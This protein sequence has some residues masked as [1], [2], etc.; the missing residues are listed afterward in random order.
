[1]L[2]SFLSSIL[3]LINLFC[4]HKLPIAAYCFKS[5][6]NE[7]ALSISFYPHAKNVLI[8]SYWLFEAASFFHLLSDKL[9]KTS[10]TA[11]NCS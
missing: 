4:C 1:M 7:F 11:M 8:K 10:I 6:F 9:Y 2:K 3:L 5:C